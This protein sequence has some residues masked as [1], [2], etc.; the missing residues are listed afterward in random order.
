M[1]DFVEQ[2]TL[3]V[4]DRS[5]ATLNKINRAIR[6]LRREADRLDGKRINIK[7]NVTGIPAARREL[8]I[9]ARVRTAKVKTELSGVAAARRELEKLAQT[10]NAR[11]NASANTSAPPGVPPAR[12]TTGAPRQVSVA[13]EPFRHMLTG[14]FHELGFVIRRAVVEGFREGASQRDIAASRLELQE[15]TP[16]ELN[17]AN[18][19]IAAVDRDFVEFN[20]G[21]LRGVFAEVNL[22][23]RGDQEANSVLLRQVADLARLQILQGED[24]NAAINSAFEFVKAAEQ[25]GATVDETGQFS[26]EASEAFFTTIKQG[27]VQGG[28]EISAQLIRTM[29][30]SLRSSRFGLDERGRITAIALSEENSTAGVGINQAIKQLSGQGNAKFRNARLEE[31]GLLE[32]KEVEVGRIGNDPV[33]ENRAAGA[34]GDGLLRRD[35]AQF[36]DEFVIPALEADGI[37]TNDPVAVSLAANEMVGNRTAV[38]ALT[39]LILRNNEL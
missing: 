18:R 16:E 35:P 15:L 13:T 23:T 11:I 26:R 24:G 14:A 17:T 7:A 32:I 9:V 29:T 6:D 27:M 34:V 20:E 3:H 19:Q 31:L 2:A 1:V 33:F 21:Q 10:R 28:V 38:E 36:V 30:K 22:I 5:T 39:S 8:S 37:D 4:K 25:S 12:G